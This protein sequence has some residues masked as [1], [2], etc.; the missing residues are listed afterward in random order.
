M[1]LYHTLIVQDSLCHSFSHASVYP[2]MNLRT[3]DCSLLSISL[4][5]RHF[6]LFMTIFLNEVHVLIT[7]ITFNSRLDSKFMSCKTCV[8]HCHYF[9]KQTFDAVTTLIISCEPHLTFHYKDLMTHLCQ[10]LA[11]HLIL[12]VSISHCLTFY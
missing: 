1:E 9:M 10:F 5:I 11:I 6:N 12:S 8:I 4:L 2:L 7:Q 3:A